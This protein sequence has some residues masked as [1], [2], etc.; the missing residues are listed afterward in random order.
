MSLQAIM[1]EEL[2]PLLSLF[3][4]HHKERGLL[5]H[6][7]LAMILG[8]TSSLYCQNQFITDPK[9]LQD[10]LKHPVLKKASHCAA[11]T[12]RTKIA[13]PLGLAF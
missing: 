9:P 4:E 7:P 10:D 2:S 8:P 1:E 11:Q 3:S 13:N 6:V 5:D 12:D